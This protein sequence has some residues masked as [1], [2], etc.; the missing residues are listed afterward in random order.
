MEIAARESPWE[1]IGSEWG[2]RGPCCPRVTAG[3]PGRREQMSTAQRHRC[4]KSSQQWA[5]KEPK[6]SAVPG[7]PFGADGGQGGRMAP[8]DPAGCRHTKAK[9]A[10]VDWVIVPL[11]WAEPP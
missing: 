11:R 10:E 4:T 6:V 7:H 3:G 5:G 8:P 1:V 9:P 2:Q